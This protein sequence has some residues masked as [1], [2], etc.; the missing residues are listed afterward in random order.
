MPCAFHAERPYPFP[1]VGADCQFAEDPAHPLIGVGGK[2][3]CR[4][5]LPL[6]A[7]DTD[8][9]RK[10]DW[11][12]SAVN[13]FNEAIFRHIDAAKAVDEPADLT[14]VA[15]PGDISFDRYRG[16]DCALPDISFMEA[17]FGVDASFHLAQFS[18]IAGF[19]MA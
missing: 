5:H 15:F 7:K 9:A 2:H 6:D 1:V 4:F 12:S 17:K 10:E 3:W 16:A 14:G 18:G 19:D 11:D 13:A 8:G